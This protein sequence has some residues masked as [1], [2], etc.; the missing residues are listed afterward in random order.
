MR[1]K[2][3]E[4]THA[5]V[6]MDDDSTNIQTTSGYVPIVGT[7]T[8][9]T[10]PAQPDGASTTEFTI[11]TLDPIAPASSPGTAKKD[12]T[13]AFPIT[14]TGIVQQSY[15]AATNTW[16]D[17]PSSEPNPPFTLNIAVSSSPVNVTK[18]E[19]FVVLVTNTPNYSTVKV[20]VLIDFTVGTGA[21]AKDCQVIVSRAAF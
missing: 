16:T 8:E 15:V 3:D 20:R 1:T 10:I 21:E 13:K 19:Q 4:S 17:I 11:S 12:K 14:I 2:Q 18:D 6:T 9:P 5:T 7:P